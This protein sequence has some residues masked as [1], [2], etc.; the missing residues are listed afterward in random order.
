MISYLVDWF[1]PRYGPIVIRY[2]AASVIGALVSL[3]AA[4]KIPV[5]PYIANAL[6]TGL[7]GIAA[8]IVAWAMDAKCKSDTIADAIAAAALTGGEM[9]VTL[10]NGG[11]AHRI[12]AARANSEGETG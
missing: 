1:L 12:S 10:P 6:I 8:A 11:G 7:A 4:H 5:A 9:E 3:L 2:A